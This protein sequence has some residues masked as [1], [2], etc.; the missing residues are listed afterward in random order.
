M[1]ERN[2]AVARGGSFENIRNSLR[3]VNVIIVQEAGE[4]GFH[5]PSCA[6]PQNMYGMWLAK[7]DRLFPIRIYNVNKVYMVN[8]V[9][10]SAQN[11]LL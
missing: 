10:V 7:P 9:D 6:S 4:A 11:L 1:A 8:F 3:R 5:L 2:P